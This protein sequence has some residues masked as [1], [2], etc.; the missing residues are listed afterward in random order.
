MKMKNMGIE[1]NYK[2]NLNTL[3]KHYILTIEQLQKE[4]IGNNMKKEYIF[5]AE[6]KIIYKIIR[7]N[8]KNKSRKENK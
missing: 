7:N 6:E 2:K 4:R 1:I 3:Y 5:L 8:I